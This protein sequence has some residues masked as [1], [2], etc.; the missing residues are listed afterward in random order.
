MNTIW[1]T[2]LR[3][4]GIGD[5]FSIRIPKGSKFLTIQI[6]HGIPVVWYLCDPKQPNEDRQIQMVVTGGNVH[7]PEEL[8]G[9]IATVQETMPDGFVFVSHYFERV[10]K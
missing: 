8:T 7:N 9:Y 6:Q 2:E 10:A 1:K 3:N 5:V 4:L